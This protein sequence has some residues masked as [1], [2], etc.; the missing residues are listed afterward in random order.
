[1]SIMDATDKKRLGKIGQAPNSHEDHH[2]FRGSLHGSMSE[3]A[4]VEEQYRKLCRNN[5][6]VVDEFEGDE[7]LVNRVNLSAFLF[8]TYQDDDRG[9]TREM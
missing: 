8:C 6:S 3:D 5:S 7:E 9:L 2:P 4:Q 1:M